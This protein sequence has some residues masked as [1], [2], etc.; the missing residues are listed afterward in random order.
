MKENVIKTVL[1]I[2]AAGLAAYFEVILIPL[3]IL[4]F[5]MVCDYISGMVSAW[6]T[7]TVSSRIGII[8]IVK[9]ACYLLVVSVAMVADWLTQ[10]ALAQ[11][12][13]A[14]SSSVFWFGLIVIIWLI[15]N[16]LISILENMGEIGIPL[17]DFFVNAIKK[18]KVAVDNS[19]R[20]EK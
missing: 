18:L 13:I 1:A 2:A 12:G 19:A 4:V 5:V 6:I 14:T 15:I 20:I 16:E 8:G 17:P 7:K 9:K 11:A 3:S 10:S